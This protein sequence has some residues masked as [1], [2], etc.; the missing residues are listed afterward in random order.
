LSALR[1]LVRL[2]F[3][4]SSIAIA[5]PT[6]K[7]ANR[8]MEAIRAGMPD[9]HLSES[10]ADRRLVSELQEASTIHRLLGS[11]PYSGG[12]RF[13]ARN[14]LKARVVIID[15]ASMIDLDL[16]NALFD[17]IEPDARLILI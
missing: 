11:K 5:A 17:A 3:D 14:R 4:A 6:G 2:G 8:M 9:I 1:V 13:N 10:L 7:A 16:M 15:E 12:F